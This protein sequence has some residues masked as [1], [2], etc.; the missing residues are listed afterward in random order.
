MYVS[1]GNWSHYHYLLILVILLLL[2]GDL[3]LNQGPS[4]LNDRIKI[5]TLNIRTIKPRTIP[6]S[7]YVTSTNLD[8]VAVTETWSKHDETKST[9][10]NISPPGY[11]FFFTNFVQISG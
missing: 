6:F 1:I 11:S 9:I 8:I 10:A 4:S 7:E 5:A 3:S 2:A